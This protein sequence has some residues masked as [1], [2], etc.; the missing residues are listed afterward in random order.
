MNMHTQGIHPLNR[1]DEAN[2]GGQRDLNRLLQGGK[3]CMV[4]SS[5]T[6]T[7]LNTD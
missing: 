5:D 2:K 4:D 1:P 3:I 6:H 7:Y